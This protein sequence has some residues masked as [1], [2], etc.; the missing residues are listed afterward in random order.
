[1]FYGDVYCDPSSGAV[2]L[3]LDPLTCS[4]QA[5]DPSI[6]ANIPADLTDTTN[7]F[8]LAWEA[9]DATETEGK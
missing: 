7:A 1:M 3:C 9:V 5:L 6:A 2:F 4:E 8:N